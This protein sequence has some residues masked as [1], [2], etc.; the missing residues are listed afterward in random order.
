MLKYV[1]S[2]I[3]RMSVLIVVGGGIDDC[4]LEDDDD[5]YGLV[6]VEPPMLLRLL[7]EEAVFAGV[8][9]FRP[10]VDFDFEF[11]LLFEFDDDAEEMRGIMDI[12]CCCLRA[13]LLVIVVLF[14]VGL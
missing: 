14:F 7:L 4:R 11:F 10:L 8:I 2:D 13:L 3:G 6:E 5:E 12:R 9:D 1:L